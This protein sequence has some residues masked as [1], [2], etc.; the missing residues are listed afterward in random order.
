MM[1]GL[2]DPEHDVIDQSSQPAPS[3]AMRRATGGHP[4][5]VHLAGVFLAF[6]GIQTSIPMIGSTS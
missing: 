3:G 5:E 1:T 6:E 4:G 2:D